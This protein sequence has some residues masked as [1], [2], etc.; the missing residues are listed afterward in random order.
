MARSLPSAVPSSTIDAIVDGRHD[1]PFS[2]L[3][4]HDAGGTLVVR[5]FIPGADA[6]DVIARDGTLLASLARRHDAGFFEGTVPRRIPYRLRASNQ[7]DTWIFDDPY[8]YG[9]LLG[10]V[11]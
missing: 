3:G 6:I 4:I 1:D 9:P 8:A 10:A 7:A 5:A 2:V 11:D